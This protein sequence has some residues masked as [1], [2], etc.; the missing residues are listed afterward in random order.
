MADGWYKWVE[1]KADPQNQQPYFIQFKS[2]AS[3]LLAALEQYPLDDG[4]EREG[5]RLVINTQPSDAD[6]LTIHDWQP[7]VLPSAAG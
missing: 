6:M 5:D 2:G 4:E 1:D 3:M 7:A